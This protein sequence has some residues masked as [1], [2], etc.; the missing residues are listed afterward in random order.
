MAVTNVDIVA[1]VH[2]DG[3][4]ADYNP[5]R[6]GS[7]LIAG[8]NWSSST[9]ETDYDHWSH[10]SSG[11][12]CTTVF[13]YLSL[14]QVALWIRVFQVHHFNGTACSP[15]YDLNDGAFT[16]RDK[17]WFRHLARLSS[18]WTAE[19][20]TNGTGAAYKFAHLYFEGGGATTRSKME[21]EN[22]T[23]L[24]CGWGPPPGSTA[25]T[26]T[27]ISQP[28]G[29]TTWGAGGVWSGATTAMH[30]DEYWEFIHCA[31]KI[32]Q[33]VGKQRFWRRQ[34]TTGSGTVINPGGWFFIGWDYV[35]NPAN[36]HTFPRCIQAK[37]GVNRNGGP[38]EDM[39]IL[40]PATEVVDGDVLS[41]PYGI[42]SHGA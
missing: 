41:D 5:N 19:N 6:L 4:P 21:F 36:T 31:Q 37:M 9:V 40:R 20:T 24:S 7:A 33:Y 12:G 8:N 30:N 38:D 27:L 26:E 28:A 16:A 15:Q 17:V 13:D 42:D 34:L 2:G 29:T 18:N 23:S 3:F 22:T 1:T 35:S 10:G 25:F 14:I 11:S 39:Y 32:S